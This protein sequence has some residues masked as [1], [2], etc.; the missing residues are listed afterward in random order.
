MSVPAID[1]VYDAVKAFVAQLAV[2][3]NEPVNV[4]VNEPLNE[5][6]LDKNWSTRFAV[7]INEGIPGTAPKPASACSLTLASG[8]Y[9][10]NW[11]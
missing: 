3:C 2:P 1:G 11:K 10:I 9:H 4:P 6:V 8:E 7:T 5:P